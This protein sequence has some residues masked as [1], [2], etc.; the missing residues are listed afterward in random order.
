MLNEKDN[1]FLIYSKLTAL[2][3][4]ILNYSTFALYIIYTHG[5]VATVFNQVVH[6]A[7][8]YGLYCTGMPSN[9]Y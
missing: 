8:C 5:Y 9:K 6:K 2:K 1:A 3:L 7:L 4:Q